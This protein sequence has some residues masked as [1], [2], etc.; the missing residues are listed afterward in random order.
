MCVSPIPLT[1]QYDF[2]LSTGESSTG[3]SSCVYTVT[4]RDG[5]VWVETPHS[6]PEAP[7]EVVEVRAVS[8]GGYASLTQRLHR[9]HGTRR[10]HR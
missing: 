3:L 1:Q 4:T 6:D 7:W 8:E 9:F 5:D 2:Q 10:A